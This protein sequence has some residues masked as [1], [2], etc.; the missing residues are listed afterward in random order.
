MQSR[1]AASTLNAWRVQHGLLVDEM[2]WL[3][4]YSVGRL[5]DKLHG[6]T[7]IGLDTERVVELV[8]LALHRGYAPPGWPARLRDAVHVNQLPS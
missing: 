6:R 7:P 2:A 5:K 4:G 8:D 3:L 1:F